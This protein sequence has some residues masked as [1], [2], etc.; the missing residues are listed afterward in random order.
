MTF[1]PRD[2]ARSAPSAA[3]ERV[4]ALVL[5]VWRCWMAGFSVGDADCLEMGWRALTREMPLDRA[6]SLLGE[7]HGFA[8][9]LVN[10]SIGRID[11]RPAT[12]RGPCRDECLVLAMLDRQQRG[13]PYQVLLA[14]R[15]LLETDELGDV[16]EATRSL[17]A[18]LSSCGL[19][20]SGFDP[21]APRPAAE[22][23]KSTI[24]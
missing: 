22:S 8:R 12:C 3:A 11:W 13:E 9:A 24:H 2:A 20:L 19:R 5:M 4:D 16:L 1:H 18:A 14:A 17:G 21:S 6:R 10:A 7:F 23:P 15:A